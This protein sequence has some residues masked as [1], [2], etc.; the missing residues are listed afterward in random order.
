MAFFHFSK[1]A[2][3]QKLKI[4]FKST[5]DVDEPLGKG[6]LVNLIGCLNCSTLAPEK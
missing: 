2:V 6:R 3:A 5:I 4:F 1:D